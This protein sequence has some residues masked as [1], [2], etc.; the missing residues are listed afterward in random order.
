MR[1]FTCNFSGRII[2][3][4]SLIVFV[5]LS[6]ASCGGGSSSADASSP[7]DIIASSSSVEGQSIA[8]GDSDGDSD[9]DGHINSVDVDADG[10]GLIEISSLAEFYAIRN[11]LKGTSLDL[12]NSDR[13][14]N[15]GGDSTGCGGGTVSGVDITSCSGYELT[16]DIDLSSYDNWVPFGGC[17]PGNRCPSL[18][19]GTFDGNNHKVSNLRMEF[20]SF[21][22]RAGLFGSVSSTSVIRNLVLSGVDISSTSNGYSFGSLVGY[23]AGGSFS[24]IVVEDALI[25]AANVLHV[26]GLIGYS[27]GVVISSS[28]VSADEIRG[29]Y[30]VGGLVGYGRSAEIS[31]SS[32]SADE[33]RGT[34]D[35][36]GLVGDGVSSLI[37]SSS[38]SVGTVAG[39]YNV[40]GLVGAGGDGT[41]SSSWVDSSMVSGID[42][43]GG[44]VGDGI[45]SGIY[46]SLASLRIVRGELRVGG[47]IGQGR[48]GR[49]VSSYVVADT[50]SGNHDVG[51]LVGYAPSSDISTSLFLGRFVSAPT[52]VGA[53]VGFS[54]HNPG[55]QSVDSSYWF[56]AVD[57]P[58]S[59]PY[60]SN[61][62]GAGKSR[63]D[64]ESPVSFSGI[65]SSWGNQGCDAGNGDFITD[66]SNPLAVD[67]NRVWDLGT[68]ND[69]PVL[70]C[71]SLSSSE[72]RALIRG[73]LDPDGDGYFD[74]DD[75]FPNDPEEH[76][77]TDAD[78][79][80][81]NS[82]NCPLVANPNQAD[83]DG[84]GSGDICD[85]DVD[86][87]GLIEIATAAEFNS[88]RHNLAGAN[89]TLSSGSSGD[90]TGCPSG[91]C[92][93]YELVS[94][95]SLSG[96]S[97]WEP[98]GSCDP[99]DF[100]CRTST[101]SFSG[102]FDGNGHSISGLRISLDTASYG[103]GLF[104]F[105]SPSSSF[106]NLRLSDVD[107]ALSA[108]AR[109]IGSLVGNG[110]GGAEFIDISVEN[111][112]I[113]AP[114]SGYVGGLVGNGGGSVVSG[115]SVS[116]GDITG[117]WWMGGLVGNGHGSRISQSSVDLGT[118]SGDNNIGGLMG[119]GSLSTIRS[120]SV[121]ADV[122]SGV[123][124][125]VGGLVGIG[126]RSV[127]S[128][129]SVI[130]GS[131]SG[132]SSVGGLIGTS[133]LG[134]VYSVL[135][136]V[137][138]LD[139]SS[140]IGGLIGDSTDTFVD[141][142]LILV[143]S[144]SGSS[145]VGGLVGNGLLANTGNYY[146][147][148][149]VA[150]PSSQP[151]SA[152]ANILGGKLGKLSLRSPVSFG[153]IYSSWGNQWCDAR[154]GN[155]ITDSSSPLAV[156]ANRVW[157][158]GTADD[159]PALRC[160]SLS[161][162][163]QRA[164]IL[165]ILDADGDDYLGGEDVFPNDSDE[166]ADADGD[167]LG[168]NA[169]PLGG[170]S[171]DDRNAGD[172]DGDG[173]FGSEDVDADG[174]GLIELATAEEFNWIRNNFAGTGLSDTEG[175]TGRNSGCPAGGCNG[176][177]L[178]ANISL[179]DYGNWEPIGIC[180]LVD[181]SAFAG[182]FDGNNHSISDVR[183]D[184]DSTG[185]RR[186][187][188]GV[189]GGAA[190]SSSFRN[191]MLM[192]VNITSNQ[193]GDDFGSLVGYADVG[194]SFSNIHAENVNID[195]PSVV[196][197]GGLIGDG[198]DTQI[199]S[200][201]V[202]AGTIRGRRSVGGLI[203]E[204][205]V[206]LSSSSVDVGTVIGESIVGG[207]VGQGRLSRISTS[208]VRAGTVGNK[209]GIGSDGSYSSLTGGLV[210]SGTSARISSS[211]V[212]VGT[213]NGG[214][215]VGGLVG[216][217]DRS[218]ISTSSV[219]VGSISGRR[220][221]AG[222]VADGREADIS[223][224]SVSAEEISG[225]SLVGGLAGNGWRARISSSS[226]VAGTIR[227]INRNV[228]GLV[229]YGELARIFSSSVF[230]ANISNDNGGYVGGLVGDG[231]LSRVF[232]T[233]VAVGAIRGNSV[234]GGLMG[235][236]GGGVQGSRINDS[237]VL[238]GSINATRLVGGITGL[239][240]PP[241]SV[242]SSYWL[243]S[244][245]F[246]DAQPLASTLTS[247]FGESKSAW[248]L[249]IFRVFAGIYADWSDAW[250]NP[251]TGAYITNSSSPLAVDANRVWDLGTFSASSE[252][253]V[254]TCG[255]LTPSQQRHAIDQVLGGN[256]PLP[257]LAP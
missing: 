177:E 76:A 70:S 176:Y 8:A 20:S 50:V 45:R 134:E 219:V 153:G 14:A 79:L 72:Q 150:F 248:E 111:I 244:V 121:K 124:F 115:S 23:A 69:L 212:E 107:I 209:I 94:D 208:S 131:I 46:S 217:G 51:G 89:L 228:G 194:S 27:N 154:N 187:A 224:S 168:D 242:I 32:V 116:G 49:I 113:S 77:D 57:F 101:S 48:L 171:E 10:D 90:A 60:P 181:C 159:F 130:V 227:G 206:Q 37:S 166:H 256:S 68:K 238:V 24:N 179:A 232:S 223:L 78:G 160:L 25:S 58:L 241:R 193:G 123:S 257:L 75:V 233:S 235:N 74:D 251:D 120:V 86:G 103:V 151:S 172:A 185:G 167:G 142:S 28:S 245:S 133:N 169:D 183:M 17:S 102:V 198:H 127:I 215:S 139:G 237:L 62:F 204:G 132:S 188:V 4:G 152:V 218:R 222:L 6:L 112:R 141:S 11:N 93:G 191:L 91:V 221:V 88:I 108:G 95:L 61:T 47:L 98:I 184:S 83:A 230:V 249:Q 161:P 207:L 220:N 170:T 85:V 41:I 200:S 100:S 97:N 22:Y 64:L 71:L 67:G 65:Y 119:L 226:V 202:R 21:A 92:R 210:G 84:D 213:I 5:L 147:L 252:Y 29:T 122:I 175:E 2:S 40:G 34:Y 33:V 35:V 174:D 178:I 15:G 138:S 87:D 211:S 39:T 56:S 156:D 165:S 125:P 26:G 80:G 18:F 186:L 197:V 99:D 254:L 137:G 43:V 195:A 3:F 155:F 225:N 30:D 110:R 246:T 55:P 31:T 196:S 243:D 53:V 143:G 173:Y 229:G 96:Y 180:H 13:N 105:A 42:D 192:N 146:W 162:S 255:S 163:E 205:R 145:S 231:R 9:G 16:A 1:L 129:S 250:C 82:D 189:F 149:S 19:Q 136:S 109:Y 128:S 7:A 236:A 81:D 12:S 164:A 158:L 214:D 44:L 135:V 36:G 201:S 104:G 247:D 216:N 240:L 140:N 54:S 63:S 148:D 73:I 253:P 199:S 157:D 144:I 182:I 59:S 118:I 117:N 126:S 114:L 203:G 106:R 66:S 239:D 38:S 190:S 234:V 52:S